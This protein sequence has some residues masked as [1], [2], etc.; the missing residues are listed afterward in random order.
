MKFF[1]FVCKY[2]GYFFWI[3]IAYL[4]L[5]FVVSILL[6]EKYYGVGE[7]IS[8]I[9]LIP[10]NLISWPVFIASTKA[11]YQNSKYRQQPTLD[12]TA[13]KLTFGIAVASALSPLIL[14]F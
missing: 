6:E 13:K 8:C 2:Y 9:L 7:L 10:L 12:R 4:V 1:S 5:V 3:E 11:D 14:I